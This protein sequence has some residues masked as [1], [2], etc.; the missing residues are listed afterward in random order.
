MPPPVA[1]ITYQPFGIAGRLDDIDE[2]STQRAILD[3]LSDAS[4][5]RAYRESLRDPAIM[6][7]AIRYFLTELKNRR[8]DPRQSGT[9]GIVFV[10]NHEEEF[11]QTENAHARSVQATLKKLSPKL[12]C[13][14]IV[15]TDPSAQNLL[16]EFIAG[17]VDVAIVKQMGAI[18][19]D[20][21]HL[22]VALDLSNTRSRAYFH[23]RMMRIT[24][25]WE[26][27]GYPDPVMESTYIAPDDR[28]TRMSVEGALKGTG[29]LRT[30]IVGEQLPIGGDPIE[31]PPI[32]WPE[33]TFTAEEVVLTGNLQDSDG[34]QGPA[35][36]IPAA[37]AFLGEFPMVS[38]DLSKAKLADFF[39]RY[40][41][42]PEMTPAPDNNANQVKYEDVGEGAT[43][44]M[45][46]ELD[47]LR[48]QC[49]DAGKKVI[50]AHFRRV[51]GEYTPEKQ[52]EFG[53]LSASYWASHFELV[54][55]PPGTQLKKIDDAEK[56]R[57]I[58]T[59]IERLKGE[60][61]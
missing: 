37:D 20:V 31:V 14:V 19:L 58:L 40:R 10:G 18:G 29:L 44:N 4:I 36:Y 7:S 3:D 22:K 47:A 8:L 49:S 17:K 32:A 27:P 51:Y 54:G 60:G 2:A 30:V 45:T 24:T 6:E 38:G 52:A 50:R 23:Q 61:E 48:K 33:P 1:G 12:R 34:V 56:L 13:E 28:I 39:R 25:L 46:K 41:F 16:D 5:R 57:A 21:D 9:S 26:V 59:N 43:P 35:S 53:R 55:L 42:N 15:S 11:D